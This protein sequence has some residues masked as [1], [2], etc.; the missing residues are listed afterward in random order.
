MQIEEYPCQNVNEA[1]ARERYHIELLKPSLNCTVPNRTFKEYYEDNKEKILTK[2]QTYAKQ[3]KEKIS[4][5]RKQYQIDK[6]DDLAEKKK[7][8]REANKEII[9]TKAIER[10]RCETCNCEVPRRHISTHNKTLKH[11]SL[12]KVE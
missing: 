12:L 9:N 4:E 11:L 2:V 1:K 10:I 6:K 7:A 3:N 5:H 8:Y